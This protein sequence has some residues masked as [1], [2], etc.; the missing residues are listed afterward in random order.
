MTDTSF[1]PSD[2]IGP[3]PPPA[4]TP[5]TTPDT[6]TTTPPEPTSQTPPSSP[7]TSL[8][9]HFSPASTL[10]FKKLFQKRS[11]DLET[12]D[13]PLPKRQHR[14]TSLE[15]KITLGSVITYGFHQ[16]HYNL[17][18][19][20]SYLP[21]SIFT[22]NNLRTILCKA[23]TLPLKKIN[24]LNLKSKPPLVLDIEIF[25]KRYGREDSLSHPAWLEATQNFVRFAGE[26]GKNGVDGAWYQRWDSHFGFFESRPDLISSF[27]PAL[28]LDICMQK[29]Y[30][31]L[32]FEY[33]PEY[34]HQE[35]EK[36]KFDFRLKNIEGPSSHAYPTHT[37]KLSAPFE[38]KPSS[39]NKQPPFRKG[40]GSD[41]STAVCL[42][43]A[44]KGH[45]CISCT[46]TSFED[47]HPLFAKSVNGNIIVPKTS[48][49]IC[50]TWNT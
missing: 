29:E 15:T 3:Q 23:N 21:L 4:E 46:S 40:A 6:E 8:L 1:P 37:S 44:K 13:D 47:G 26:T 9:A 22:N 34:Y 39:Q 17:D 18:K 48:Q 5:G 31:A 19:Y 50:H 12:N 25:E 20:H 43:C 35:Y 10:L 2:S 28:D 42:I 38:L 7:T 36:A 41:P 30:N 24:P 32:P 33:S 16:L 49:S 11:H 14:D 27:P 45:T